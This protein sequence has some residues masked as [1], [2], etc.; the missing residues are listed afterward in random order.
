MKLQELKNWL[1]SHRRWYCLFY[2]VFYLLSFVVLEHIVTEPKYVIHCALDDKIP[3]VPFFVIPYFLWYIVLAGSLLYFVRQE[4]T[5]HF[6]NLCLVC[7]GGMTFA[8]FIYLILPNGV[9]LRTELPNDG[10]L[11]KLMSLIYAADT[12]T[13]VCPSIHVSSTSAI[14]LAIWK[15]ENLR[16][17]KWLQVCNW[18][19]GTSICISTVFVHQHSV[20]DVVCGYLV[21][22]VLYFVAYHTNWQEV[23]KASKLGFLAE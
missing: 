3:F 22:I 8:L 13:N 14:S 21:T 15:D 10:I 16:Q 2:M 5:K 7:F 20:I 6:L 18:V 17:K 11:C 23:L 9:N 4:D 12:S 1:Q 19:I